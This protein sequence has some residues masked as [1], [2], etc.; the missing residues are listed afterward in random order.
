[1]SRI[2]DILIKVN[3]AISEFGFRSGK[4]ESDQNKLLS[5]ITRCK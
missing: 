4:N 5:I 2:E 3:D 1:M